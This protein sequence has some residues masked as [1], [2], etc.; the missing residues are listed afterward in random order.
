MGVGIFASHKIPMRMQREE[1]VRI[2]INMLRGISSLRTGDE[3]ACS[4]PSSLFIY[5]VSITRQ[6]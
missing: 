6:K 4:V 3:W 1:R 5:I 2:G